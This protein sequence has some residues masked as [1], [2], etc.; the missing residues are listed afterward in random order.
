MENLGDGLLRE[1]VRAFDRRAWL[2][3]HLFRV[4]E[5]QYEDSWSYALRS[6]Q[7]MLGH[8]PGLW[9]KPKLLILDE[10][11]LGLAADRGDEIFSVIDKINKKG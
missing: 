4:L 1:R 11:S 7:Q 8:R 2:W 10:P 9:P 5:K 3:L 6:E